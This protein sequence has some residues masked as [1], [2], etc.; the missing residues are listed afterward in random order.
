[1][2][3]VDLI[4]AENRMLLVM[5]ERDR[6]KR[7][8]ESK[9]AA[10]KEL[11]AAENRHQA[12]LNE[13]EGLSQQLVL[14]GLPK[15]AVQRVRAE[16]SICTFAIISPISGVV[17][18]RHVVLGETVEPNKVIFKILDPSVVFVEG[19]AFEEAL[20]R[21]RI[22]QKA[23]IR[24]AS[25]P[26]ELF[27]GRIS[28]FSPMI[29]PRKR[30]IRLWVEVKN[31]D[32]RLKPDLF[33]DMDIVVGGGKEV[34][35]IPVEALITTEGK[36][37]AFVENEGSFRRTDL[38]LGVRDDRYVEVKEGL[39]QGEHVVTDGKQ[40]LYTQ[41]LMARQGGAALGGHGH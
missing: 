28:R 19:D 18:E 33:A 25:Y 21:L 32:G 36:S 4:Q 29:D 34:L 7:L 9:I 10:Q 16:K 31:R 30:T 20:P 3:Q 40:Q 23:R 11:I 38:S 27:T 39:R 41:S 12:V 35:A 14:M 5:A 15:E 8:V 37:F 1:K 24:V 6:V 22:G 26:G 2:L 17:A 13:I